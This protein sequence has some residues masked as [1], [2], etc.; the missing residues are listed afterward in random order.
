MKK[1]RKNCDKERARKLAEQRNDL[2]AKMQAIRNAYYMGAPVDYRRMKVAAMAV[3]LCT[4]ALE[5]EM[6]GR[7]YIDVNN[8]AG[9][10]RL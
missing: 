2:I 9:T 8:T 5:K 1:L 10:L 6:Y 7:C 4:E 3:N